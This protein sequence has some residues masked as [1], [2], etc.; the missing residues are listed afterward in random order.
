MDGHGWGEAAND[1]GSGTALVM[2]LARIFSSPDVQTERSIRFA[3]WNN[4]ETGLNG[5]RAYVEQRQA[6]QGKEDPAGSGQVSGAE[7]ARH[8]PARH[9]DVRPRHAA[10][11]R[12]GRARSS[13]PK[14]TSTSSSRRPSK[15]AAEAAGS[16][17]GSF[18]AANEKY[19]TDYPAAVGTA[20]DEHRLGAVH[21]H[22]AG[23]QPARER[24]RHA[25]RQRAGIRTGTSR[26]TCSRRSATRTSASA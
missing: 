5:A 10:R 15:I 16:S 22:R 24:A 9:D 1:D 20:H 14:R 8:D 7:V 3:L 25:D 19:A 2:E 26:R 4:E 23:D 21:G 11:R 12:H 18:Q 17:R 6:L 13:A